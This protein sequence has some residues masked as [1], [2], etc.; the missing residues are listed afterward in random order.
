VLA[1]KA[2]KAKK[3]AHGP[4]DSPKL[5]GVRPQIDVT[6][7]TAQFYAN[8]IEITNSPWDFSLI[9]ATLPSKLNR[10]QVEEIQATG[11]IPVQAQLTV[12]FPPTLLAGLIRALTT[13]KELYE[14]T[15]GTEL[16]E[17]QMKEPE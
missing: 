3:A 16:V 7:N 1:K 15:M 14:T 8:F 5:V 2:K 6:D 12:N 17:P 4:D 10:T 9:S 11:T 13:Q